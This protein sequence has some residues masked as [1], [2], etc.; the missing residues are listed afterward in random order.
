MSDS[1]VATKRRI[2]TIQ[3][4][5][6]ITK[7]M[8]LVASVKF[9]KW[10]KLL[11]NNKA[12][13][14]GMENVMKKTVSAIDFSKVKMPDCLQHFSDT[15]NLY[16]VVTSS[17]GLCGSY[18]Y[19]L[20]RLL[21]PLLK[22]DDE[23]IVL[24]QKGYLH[25]KESSYI[26]HEDYVNLMDEF[27]FNN[28]KAMRHFFLRLYRSQIYKTV[29]LVYTHYKNSMTFVPVVKQLVPLDVSD[30]INT[31]G[32]EELT[33][34]PLFDPDP[35]TVADLVL[36]HY[37]DALLYSSL[38]ESELSEQSSRRNAMETATDSADKLNAQLKI[39]YNKARQGAITQEITEVVSGAN[40][41]KDD[42]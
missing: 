41:G 30:L 26:L 18:N 19:N 8:K 23:I 33:Y 15:K 27:T 28:V 31:D 32:E 34:P 24:G 10:H 42:D 25:Y 35:E 7:A 17:L 5:E 37:I 29:T 3:S 36:P 21:D 1:L 20:F 12:Y 39:K 11:E 14:S 13:T 22:P 4:T 9:Q 2:Q 40:T 16:V 38:I 6:K